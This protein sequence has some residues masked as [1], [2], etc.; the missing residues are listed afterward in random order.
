MRLSRPF[1]R[2]PVR[3]DVERLRSEIAALP[4]SAWAKHPNHIAGNSCVRLISVAGG[5]NDDVDG[6]MQPTPHLAHLSY[7]RQVLASFGVVWSRSRLLRLAPGAQVPEH[8]DINYHW[9]NRVRL[10]IPVITRP[11]VRFYCGDQSVHMAAGEAWLFDNWRRHR[12]ENPTSDERIHIV[13]DTSGS[14]SFWQFVAQSDI[15]AGSAREL[16]YDAARDAAPLTER[17]VLAP[18]MAPAEVDLLTLDLRSELL[19][20]SDSDDA[21]TRLAR[22]HGMLDAMCRDWRQLYSLHGTDKEGWPELT[23]L[24]DRVRTASQTLGEGLVM[25]T[26]GVPA[27]AV[28]EGR[29][30]RPMLSAHMPEPT[31]SRVRRSRLKE[32]TF[33][34]AA[35]RSGSTLL[36]ETLARS[37]Q[38]YTLGGEGHALIEGL[39]QLQP[40]APRV[41]SNRLDASQAT[42]E[43]AEHV[44]AQIHRE[45][46]RAHG[47][48]PPAAG[49]LRFLEKTPK[50]ALRVPFLKQLFPDARFILL[51]RDPRENLSSIIEAWRSGQWKT[52]NG[53]DGFDGP[54]SLLLPPGWRA[55]QGRPLEDIAAFQW[56]SANRFALS[57]LAELPASTWKAVSYAQLLDDPRATIRALCEFIGIEF[58]ASLAEHTSRPLPASRFTLTAPEPGKWRRNE[59]AIERVLPSV[60]QTWDRLRSLR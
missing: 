12:V 29:V 58:D 47:Q 38:L 16:R 51:W 19:S 18:V 32:P 31:S 34:I 49:D 53:L 21:R 44:L 13:A 2:L 15:A 40:G 9:F 42:A 52:Y 20:H 41:D 43:V 59:V 54:W 28:L 6:V 37:E 46:R 36:F 55:M 7:V 26:N 23:R 45:M 22:Y 60:T 11:E 30:L 3:F 5:E 8:A 25:R 33:I 14:A 24:R 27:H 48:A 39:E 35:P 17:T 50:N 57:D 56:D 10:H 4:A 1:Y